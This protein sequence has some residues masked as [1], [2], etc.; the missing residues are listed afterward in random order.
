MGSF[1]EPFTA[2]RALEITARQRALNFVPATAHDYSN[3]GYVLLALVVERV[4][5]QTFADWCAENI[6]APL[7]M[8]A[9]R[10][11]DAP[12]N[13]IANRAVA[14]YGQ[15][16][17]FSF[18]QNNGMCLIGSSA[19]FSSPADMEKWMA[20]LAGD[21]PA[22]RRMMQPGQLADGTPVGYGFGLSVG[23]LAGQDFITHSG[24]TPAGFR[25]LIALLPASDIRLM[26]LS[27]WGNLDPINDLGKP[28]LDLLLDQQP[29][30][31][32]N[33][34]ISQEKFTDSI[35]S[36]V[37]DSY[38]GNYLFNGELPVSVS[39]EGQVLFVAVAD[40]PSA[41]LERRSV[42]EFY[43]ELM[44]SMLSFEL[45]SE[46]VSRV[47]I[48]Q[49]GEYHGELQPVGNADSPPSFTIPP[50]SNGRFYSE[51]LD[52][53]L[54]LTPQ[55]GGLWLSSGRHGT[56][57]LLQKSDK[58]FV[59]TTDLFEELSL[60]LDDAGRVESLILNLGSR[61]REIRFSRW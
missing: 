43:S 11:N 15:E 3:T 1:L 44:N 10:V 60:E 20:F 41:P 45:D 30:A 47:V 56:H 5:G 26:V 2:G 25:T 53:L 28:I 13:L 16:G 23:Q 52:L 61:A 27:S 19:V 22:V 34:E 57:E 50:A 18:N 40:R 32:R 49:E 29:V 37:L 35:P 24:A 58:G 14:Y 31:K 59:S 38:V 51:E 9:T 39:R 7:E 42:T 46:A 36:E 33:A 6:F 4:T 17:K 12:D 55:D 21:D 8:T 54:T 48:K